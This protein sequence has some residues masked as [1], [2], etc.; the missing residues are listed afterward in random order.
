LFLGFESLVVSVIAVRHLDHDSHLNLT[1]LECHLFVFLLNEVLVPDGGLLAWNTLCVIDGV[2]QA[3]DFAVATVGTHKVDVNDLVSALHI[4]VVVSKTN[5]TGLVLV[6]DKDHTFGVIAQESLL[7]NF[8]KELNFEFL[9]RLP[10]LVITN[11]NLDLT[12]TLL[13]VHRNQLI[14]LDVVFTRL[15][16]A[17]LSANP[18]SLLIGGLLLNCDLDEAVGLSDLI[19]E[20][21]KAHSLAIV[22]RS[23]LGMV[24]LTFL[25]LVKTNEVSSVGG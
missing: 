21:L 15:G 10:A 17:V 14:L 18:E 1:A 22:C 12:L 5:A 7:I 20:M 8:V 24:S 6:L 3:A 9:I 25:A 2:E 11:F 23:L 16:S 19:F 4:Q 13:R